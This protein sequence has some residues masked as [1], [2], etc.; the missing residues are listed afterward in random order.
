MILK[1][2]LVL[3]SGWFDKYMYRDLILDERVVAYYV[4]KPFDNKLVNL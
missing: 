1:Y 4:N 2:L 3:M